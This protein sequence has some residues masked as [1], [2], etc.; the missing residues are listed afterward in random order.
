MWHSQAIRELSVTSPHKYCEAREGET[1][2]D[3]VYKEVK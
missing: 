3:Q 1:S 2:T